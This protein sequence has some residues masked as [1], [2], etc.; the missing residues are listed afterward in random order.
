VTDWF[1]VGVLL[2]LAVCATVFLAQQSESARSS[3]SRLRKNL[4]DDLIR[5]LLR[6][7]SHDR[8]KLL[9][10]VTSP[11]VSKTLE[12]VSDLRTLRENI[13]EIGKVWNDRRSLEKDCVLLL[14]KHIEMIFPEFKLSPDSELWIGHSISTI[15]QKLFQFTPQSVKQAAA[16]FAK[17][18]PRPEKM[19]DLFGKFIVT[20]PLSIASRHNPHSIYLL[21]EAK[22][23]SIPCSQSVMDEAFNYANDLL[24]LAETEM[25]NVHF[26]CF[27]I[28]GEYESEPLKPIRKS[29]D[30]GRGSISVVPLTWRDLHDRLC[31]L[32]TF[33][34]TGLPR[35]LAGNVNPARNFEDDRQEA[36]EPEEEQPASIAAE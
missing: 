2:L 19:P 30:N 12:Q 27:A 16:R 21:I 32:P 5:S 22:R 31:T 6:M 1:G 9:S 29:A 28:G 7:S 3:L 33:G 11:D 10:V 36:P 15:L 26:E 13:D 24:R 25:S 34:L 4:S 8:S 20:S 35:P 23:P 17:F 18:P 14:A